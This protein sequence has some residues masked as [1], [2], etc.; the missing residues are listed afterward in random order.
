MKKT[1]IIV[2]AGRG[3]GNHVAEKFGENGFRVVLMAR[4]EQ[5]LH[6][7]EK[8][9]KAKGI[10]TY[11]YP[12]D[13]V[14][15]ESVR[16]AFK[17]A[18]TQLGTPDVL[19]YNVGIT[20]PDNPATLDSAEL[21]RHFKVD[22]AGAYT[23]I[24]QVVDDEFS[25]KNGTIILTGGHAALY[26]FPGYLCLALDKAALRNLALALHNDLKERGIF[27]GTVTVGGSIQPETHF[28]P[29]LIAQ[30][31]W[32]MYTERKDWELRYE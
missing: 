29:E 31:F 24:Q 19:I 14:N 25:K 18:K 22:V 23:C 9:F 21:E 28:A 20:T 3:L 5:S 13:V 16:N 27:I 2:G 12:V 10:E 7:Y 26:P 11:V 32:Q 8:E 4:N 30:T 17:A 15:P 6:E 1:V